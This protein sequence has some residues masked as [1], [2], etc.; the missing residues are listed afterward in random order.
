M[1]SLE[2]EE[3][4]RVEREGGMGGGTGGGTEGETGEVK[5]GG[6]RQWR[7]RFVGLGLSLIRISM[8]RNYAI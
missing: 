3:D 7:G 6:T 4:R 2:R 5:Q 1:F 8:C